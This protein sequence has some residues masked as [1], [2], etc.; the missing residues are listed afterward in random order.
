MVCLLYTFTTWKLKLYIPLLGAWKTLALRSKWL[1]MF[2]KTCDQKKKRGAHNETVLCFPPPHH[3]HASAAATVYCLSLIR[4]MTTDWRG[5]HCLVLA[6]QMFQAV[7]VWAGFPNWMRTTGRRPKPLG[8]E[9]LS[10]QPQ[11]LHSAQ[12]RFDR[13]PLYAFV[14][15]DP[16]R[17]TT[18]FGGASL[19]RV[20]RSVTR[21]SDHTWRERWWKINET[22]P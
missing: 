14:I 7:A 12:C 6:C 13:G 17:K 21:R 3:V 16:A 19:N 22:W 8:R 10:E 2:T 20:T 4:T 1:P 18:R 15:N 9:K 11:K 5:R